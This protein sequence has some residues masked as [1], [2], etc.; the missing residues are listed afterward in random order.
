V[1]LTRELRRLRESA[2]KRVKKRGKKAFERANRFLVAQSRV[3][4]VPA[5]DSRLFPWTI[6]L[7]M[8]WKVV[9]D[10][11]ERVLQVREELPRLYEISPDNH[12]LSSDDR[13]KTFAIRG[14][15][16]WAALGRRLCP[17]TARLLKR[18][19]RLESAFFSVLDPGAR[20]P[21][22]RGIPKGLLR[23][24]LGMIVPEDYENCRIILN[25]VPY[26]WR[27]GRAFVFDDTYY[28][29]VHNQTDQQ[30]IVLLLDFERPMRWRGRFVHRTLLALMRRT[31]HV[32]EPRRAVAQW[33]KQLR[34]KL[35]ALAEE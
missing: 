9:R 22:H 31:R 18:V 32:R 27:E 24:H 23:C 25:G 21:L 20:I 1:A 29:E 26:S 15:G 13:W 4:D 33:E 2:H 19:P 10:E 7:E 28:H 6:E 3:P 14:F 30:R 17:E 16:Y 11:L 35:R 12:R 5:Y 34:P 8:N